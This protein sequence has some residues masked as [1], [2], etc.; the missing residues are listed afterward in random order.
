MN[1]NTTMDT[2]P[3]ERVIITLSGEGFIKRIPE[4]V[5]QAQHSRG[6][7]VRGMGI[8]G[9]DAIRLLTVADNCDSI[10]FFTN[11]GNIFHLKCHEI[12]ADVSRTAKGLPIKNLV[13]IP[14]GESVIAVVSVTEFKPLSF[15]ILATKNGGIKK[16]SVIY[17]KFLS[18]SGRKALDLEPG[19]ELVSVCLASDEEG[20]IVVTEQGQSL[21]L[22]A[23]DLGLNSPFVGARRCIQLGKE[24]KVVSLVVI[25]H[26]TSLILVTANGYGKLTPIAE[27]TVQSHGSQGIKTFK[28]T[29]TTGMVVAAGLI[30]PNQL[31]MLISKNGMV[32]STP[33][34][35][36]DGGSIPVLG[37]NTQGVMMMRL[38][39][40]DMVAALIV[41]D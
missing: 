3:H 14:F 17:F 36:E 5:Y 24:D 9:S 41:W 31:L 26:D 18:S 16:M 27:Y 23:I 8:R 6:K 29:A 15:F 40:G 2:V 7:D 34:T 38:D 1:I 10:F 13:S 22:E 20:I 12:P 25:T 21:R 4:V 11:A 39:E 32:I 30:S 37:S 33:L 35:D 28:V 19:D